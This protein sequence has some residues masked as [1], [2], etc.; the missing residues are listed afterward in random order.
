MSLEYAVSAE[1]GI[2]N[3]ELQRVKAQQASGPVHQLTQS[4]IR[5][6]PR[7]HQL[8]EQYDVTG[9]V[10]LSTIRIHTQRTCNHHV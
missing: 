7:Y 1:S 10:V 2:L 5:L 4:A 6:Q 9:G 8:L 3:H